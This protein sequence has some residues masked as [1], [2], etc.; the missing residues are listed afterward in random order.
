MPAFLKSRTFLVLLGLVLLSLLLWFVGPYFAFAEYKPLDHF[1]YPPLFAVA[2]T[3]F[4]LLGPR[5]GGVLWS[6]AGIAVLVTARAHAGPIVQAL[7]VQGIEV[8]GVDLV[9]LGEVPVVRDLAA[10][11]RALDHLGDRTAWLAVLRAPWCGLTLSELTL[12]AGD[13][14]QLV[15]GVEFVRTPK[16]DPR[17]VA[18]RLLDDPIPI[19][20]SQLESDAI[21]VGMGDQPISRLMRRAIAS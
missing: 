6:W 10:L 16:K 20:V 12:F 1:R 11:T 17:A 2:V 8:A 9:P 5:A 3:P 19:V 7:T 15:R 14:Q 21:W 13:P 4:S 18:Q